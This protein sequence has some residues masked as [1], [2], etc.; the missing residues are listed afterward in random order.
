MVIYKITNLLNLKSYIGQTTQEVSIRWKNHCKPSR[1]SAVSLAIQKYGKEN[2]KFQI[3]DSASSIEELNKK[4]VEWI[5]KEKTISPTGYNLRSGGDNSL[6][7]EETKR[8]QGLV[9]IGNKNPMFGVNCETL[10]NPE[11]VLIKN[12]KIS[13][14]K[15]GKSSKSGF[16]LTGRTKE[17]FSYLKEMAIKQSLKYKNEGNP[18]AKKVILNGVEYKTMKDASLKTGLSM[19]KLR[20]MM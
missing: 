18:N 20:K 2:F 15:K 13:Q 16:K 19:Y 1:K 5:E 9:K 8:K 17:N 4:E 12:K 7:H 6:H 10:M 14:S 3:I 11:D